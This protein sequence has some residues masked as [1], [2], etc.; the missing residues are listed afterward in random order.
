[1]SGSKEVMAQAEA[2]VR[3][4]LS[5]C[6]AELIEWIDTA[7]LR[8]GKVREAARILQPVL[9]HDAIKVAERI[10]ERAALEQCALEVKT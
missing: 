2:F 1:M 7:V 9:H 6:A 8:D 10:V 3:E 4:N 5:E